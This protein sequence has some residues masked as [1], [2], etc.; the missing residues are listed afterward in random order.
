MS[1]YSSSTALVL[2]AA[3]G[4]VSHGFTVA[5]ELLITDQHAAHITL[6]PLLYAAASAGGAL[7]SVRAAADFTRQRPRPR[8]LPG[9]TAATA[10]PFSQTLLGAGLVEADGAI[11]YVRWVAGELDAAQAQGTD[12]ETVSVALA[13][14]AFDIAVDVGLRQGERVWEIVGTSG[15]AKAHRFAHLWSEVRTHSAAI[16][17]TARR[18]AIGE[19]HLSQPGIAWAATA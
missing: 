11:S 9:V 3:Q 15:V 18:R 7:G 6:K 17:R 2:A 4:D 12:G 13:L 19:A 8:P 1:T 16:P 5:D 10:D 14:A